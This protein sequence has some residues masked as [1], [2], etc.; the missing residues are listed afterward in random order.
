MLDTQ[1][2]SCQDVAI[3]TGATYVAEE[4]GITLDQV[5]VQCCR[6]CVT[7]NKKLIL[8]TLQN[9]R[10]ASLAMRMPDAKS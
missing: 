5:S 1:S 3:A 10:V 6:I 2:A 8:L 4:V 7:W 9:F